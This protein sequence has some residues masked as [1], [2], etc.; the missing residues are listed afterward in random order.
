MACL[1]ALVAVAGVPGG[2]FA[3]QADP[4]ANP[5]SVYAQGGAGGAYGDRVAR[6]K[7]DLL[8]VLIDEASVAT[9]SANTKTSKSVSNSTASN[10]LAALNWAFGPFSNSG[11]HANDGKGSTDHASKMTTRMS[12]VV[13][14]VDEAGNLTVEGTRSLVTNKETQTFILTG[15]VRPFDISPENTVASTKIANAEI[16]MAGKGQIADRQRRGVLTQV[17]DWLF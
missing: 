2:A 8:M 11:E 3:Q 5:G 9:F 17:L 7:G 14:S 16:R 4:K 13:K 15:V 1:V 6:K 10:V 12:V